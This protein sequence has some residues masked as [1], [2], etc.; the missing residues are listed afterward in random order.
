MTSKRGF[1][2][3]GS[4]LVDG[5]VGDVVAGAGAVVGAAASVGAGG[6]GGV[7]AG[8]GVVGAWA[9]TWSESAAAANVSM[10]EPSLWQPAETRGAACVPRSFAVI[11]LDDAAPRSPEIARPGVTCADG[12]L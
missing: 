9:S 2:G 12:P 8:A 4:A 10:C 7:S 5:A 1:V 11:V 3:A 6:A